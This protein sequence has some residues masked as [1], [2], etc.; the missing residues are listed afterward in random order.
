MTATLYTAAIIGTDEVLY[1]GCS[2]A[3]KTRIT[4]HRQPDSPLHK[5]FH[6][7]EFR[8]LRKVKGNIRKLKR[9]E[10]QVTLAYKQKGLCKLN[11][12]PSYTLSP[13]YKSIWG[14]THGK[15]ACNSII[16][17]AYNKLK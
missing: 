1:V 17:A 11:R 3:L 15:R 7:L 10:T 2:R 8:I 13:S 12:C 9:I 6:K 5:L 14:S 4:Q 16:E